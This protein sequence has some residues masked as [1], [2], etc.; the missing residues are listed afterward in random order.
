MTRLPFDESEIHAGAPR[1][2]WLGTVIAVAILA[3]L[4]AVIHLGIL[5]WLDVQMYSSCQ[6][7]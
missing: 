6:V 4:L 3:T 7:H 2:G 5:N 1:G